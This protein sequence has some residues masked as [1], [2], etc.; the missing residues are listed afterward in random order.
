MFR[1]I[2][3]GKVKISVTAAAAA[4]L[5]AACGGGTSAGGSGAAGPPKSGGTL[6]VAL[7]GDP[8]SI[9][10]RA[11]TPLVREVARPIVDSLLALDPATK[12]PVPWLA[13]SFRANADATEFTFTLRQGVT[14]SDGTPLTAKVVKDNF[15]DVIT[16]R[17]ASVGSTPLS[18]LD[19]GGYKG[20]STPDERTVVQRFAKPYPTWPLWVTNPGFGILAPKTLALPIADR[21]DKVIGTGPFVLRSYV[22]NSQVVLTRRAGYKW[23]PK[24]RRHDGDAYLDKVVYRIIA[25]P[26]VRTGALK[27]GQV[28]LAGALNPSDIAPVRAAGFGIVAQRLPRLAE[29]LVVT[30]ADRAPL[31]DPAVRQALVKAVDAKQIR[32]TLLTSEWGVPTS[33]VTG[34][35]IGHSD[36]SALLKPDEA[37]AAALLDKAGWAPGGDGIRAKDGRRLTLKLGWLNRGNP[38]DQPLVELV[39]AR[40]KKIGVELKPELVTAAQSVE[41]LKA[42][43][44]W[45][46]FL[47]GVAGGPDAGVG[48][49]STFTS[50]PPNFFNVQD[51]ALQPLL[52]KQATTTDQAA[53]GRLVADAQRRVLAEG[54]F[55]PLVEDTAVVAVGKKVHGFALDADARLPALLDVWLS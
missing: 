41:A 19:Q 55:T 44:K 49:A 33:V 28:Q 43:N 34:A 40:Y 39:T 10:P 20:T 32:D 52:E 31:K 23:G 53:R 13:E 14:F 1:T 18:L 45:D 9:Y 5:L 46:L 3:V 35:V 26:S 51:A 21:F 47:S 4:L 24:T 8:V 29:G 15:D 54:L 27:T 17:A 2:S 50:A 16:N 42:R 12:Q 25:E 37:A 36:Q 7:G 22:R 30:G 6:T 48:L 38:W 11:V